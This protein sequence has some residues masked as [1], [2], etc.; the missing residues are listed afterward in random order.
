LRAER[1]KQKTTRDAGGRK[2]L[3][4]KEI[5]PIEWQKFKPAKQEGVISIAKNLAHSKWMCAYHIVFTPK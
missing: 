1:P 5:T 3:T 2:G 4:E